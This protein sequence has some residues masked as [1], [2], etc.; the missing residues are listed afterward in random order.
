MS[1]GYDNPEQK[2]IRPNYLHLDIDCSAFLLL[3]D[4]PPVCSDVLVSFT[5]RCWERR[6]IA[7]I[8]YLLCITIVYININLY[9][10]LLHVLIIM[11]LSLKCV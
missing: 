8:R 2:N 6:V 9:V 7:L 10:N 11:S 1:I 4:W 3:S 5:V